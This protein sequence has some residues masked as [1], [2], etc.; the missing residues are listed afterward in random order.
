MQQT[1]SRKEKE[2]RR[3]RQEILECAEQI[4][5]RKG[6]YGATIGEV[7]DA[8]DFSVGSIYQYFPSKE[9]LYDSL[10]QDRFGTFL[11]GLRRLLRRNPA[12]PPQ[13]LRQVIHYTL[14][15][16]E[17]HR[18][19]FR[20]VLAEMGNVEI[21]IHAKVNTF[22]RAKRQEYMKILQGI[23]LQGIRS[24]HFRLLDPFKAALALRG[25]LNSFIAHHLMLKKG[26][27]LL[28]EEET[29]F[30]LLAAGT[31]RQ[32]PALRNRAH[33]SSGNSR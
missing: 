6:Y 9:A 22:I 16:A 29:I 26:P 30:Q 15:Y 17:D 11:D 27:S 18:P 7:A 32:K 2:R 8:S 5:A 10:I 33:G 1:G 24:G 14:A 21:G 3:H 4:F 19:F 20:I 28:R 25:I 12:S 23:F 13:Q 31:M